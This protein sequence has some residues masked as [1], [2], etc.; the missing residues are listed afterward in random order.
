MAHSI[1]LPVGRAREENQKDE[2]VNFTAEAQLCFVMVARYFQTRHF[3]LLIIVAQVQSE[4][5]NAGRL[6]KQ[7]NGVLALRSLNLRILT[8]HDKLILAASVLIL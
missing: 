4:W 1:S 7:V 8:K 5:L 2:E 3:V 6:S